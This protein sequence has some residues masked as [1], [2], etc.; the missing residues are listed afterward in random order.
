MRTGHLLLLALTPAFSGCAQVAL[1]VF[2]ATDG[3]GG[4]SKGGGNP[5]ASPQ[6]PPP[7]TPPPPP[8][9][10]PPSP[11]PAPD[12]GPSPPPT[13]PP[14]APPGAAPTVRSISPAW[15]LEAGG[16]RLTLRGSGFA[17]ANAGLPTVTI[18]GR[19]APG[20]V[21]LSD[22]T[23]TCT[24]P[25]ADTLAPPWVDVR[26]STGNGASTLLHGLGYATALLL[27]DF[28]SGALPAWLEAPANYF[29]ID[30]GS[31]HD[32]TPN[33]QT[34]RRYCRTVDGA[35]LDRDFA[36]E[37]SVTMG[38]DY[39]VYPGMGSGEPDFTYFSEAQRGVMFR[40]HSPN[41]APQPGRIDVVSNDTGGHFEFHTI[42]ASAVYDTRRVR[43]VKLG[44]SM[45]FAHMNGWTGQSAFVGELSH[46]FADLAVSAPYLTNTTSHLYF[47]GGAPTFRFDDLVIATLRPSP[48]RLAGVS[49][50]AGPPNTQVTITGS[51]FN[52]LGPAPTVRIGLVGAFS[53]A[54]LNDT[55][56]QC[57]VPAGATGLTDVEVRGTGGSA[58]LFRAFDRQASAG[59]GLKYL[60]SIKPIIMARG[61]AAAGCHNSAARLLQLALQDDN[62]DWTSFRAHSNL[63][64]PPLS[65]VLVRPGG[66][67]H[68]LAY[69]SFAP[70]GADYATIV[71]WISDGAQF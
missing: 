42:G 43:I 11:P 61:C 20:V 14:P 56:L 35:W 7:S 13:P 5:T 3:G 36:Y 16:A 41:V 55:T 60:T 46:T 26:V 28:S 32:N 27:E 25:A 68:P 10:P 66:Q 30:N 52:G 18:D 37:L 17:A 54:V 22:D 63:A 21:V 40:I 31:I 71:Q 24:A 53:V 44:R 64:D 4:S 39:I 34:N 51:G 23:L 49:P 1:G 2:L 12:P 6:P 38:P 9:A 67:N 33:D 69:P 15:T 8:P 58:V 70:G 50:G 59:G 47:G 45:W 19:P 57:S 62:A 29:F 65:P 48:V